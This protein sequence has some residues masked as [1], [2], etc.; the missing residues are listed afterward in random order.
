MHNP[1]DTPVHAQSKV[2]LQHLDKFSLG[3]GEQFLMCFIADIKQ[4]YNEVSGV[5]FCTQYI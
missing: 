1:H 4:A 5:C 2:V 3:I